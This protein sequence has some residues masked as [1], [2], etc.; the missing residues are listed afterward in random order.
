M[1]KSIEI[2]KTEFAPLAVKM[3]LSEKLKDGDPKSIEKVFNELDRLESIIKDYEMLF[4]A[5]N[6][7]QES[8]TFKDSLL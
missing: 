8:K 3:Y 1:P 4:N 5:I 2:I 6:V 7:R